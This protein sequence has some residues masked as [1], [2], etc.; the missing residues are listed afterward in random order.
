MDLLNC[1]QF[2]NKEKSLLKEKIFNAQHILILPHSRADGDALGSAK[3]V[4]LILQKLGKTFEIVCP[5]SPKVDFSCEYKIAK[6]DQIPDLL[7]SV[8][9]ASK[10]RCFFPKEFE[11]I[12]FINIDHHIS[13]TLYADV[14][15]IKKAPS[16][17]EVLVSLFAAVFGKNIFDQDIAESFLFGMM[18]DTLIFSTSEVSHKTF[19]TT[20]FLLSLEADYQKVKKGVQNF[21]P[22]KQFQLWS[23]IIFRA[24]LD[25]NNQILILNVNKQIINQLKLKQNDFVGFI[26][27]VSS[28]VDTDIIIF[29]SEFQDDTIDVSMRS[30]ITDV[31]KIA[32][33]FSGGG[34]K[35]AAG[36][37]VKNISNLDL[38][39]K[40]ITKIKIILN[41]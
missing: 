31:S 26:N 36:F 12:F 18:T 25:I 16:A 15:I 20:Q 23:E 11:S 39:K 3:G 30:K 14:N 41:D 38:E 28:N 2:D 37:K 32:Q 6:Y 24:K 1:Y 10:E 7:I 5:D 17:C 22:I 29:I 40:L 33:S 35:H 13:N 8:D 34:H 9:C 21:L 4:A 27:H 19:T